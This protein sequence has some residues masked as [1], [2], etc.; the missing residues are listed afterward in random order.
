MTGFADALTSIKDSVMNA[1][2][3]AKQL[4]INFID[5]APRTRAEVERRLTRA[6]YEDEVIAA[7][8]T[9][10]ERIGLLNDEEFSALWVESR[11][12]SKRLGRMRLSAELRQKGVSKDVVD[13][14]VGEISEESEVASATELA[15]KRLKP[16]EY[17]DLS[18]RRRVAAYLRRRG[19]N[20]EIIEQVFQ[21]LFT[22]SD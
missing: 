12:R 1:F 22:N 9:D 16:E 4:A 11:S 21:K 18:A 15:Q 2:E 17:E 20:W 19:Y 7:V 6:G 3:E 10:L 8:T 14:A 5:Y 13:E